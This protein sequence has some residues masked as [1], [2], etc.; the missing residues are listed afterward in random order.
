M[1]VYDG[2]VL[3]KGILH[4]PIAGDVLSEKIKRKLKADLDYV[5][6][7]HYRIAKKKPVD[8]DEKPDIQLRELNG[9]TESF[10]DNQINVCKT[11]LKIFNDPLTHMIENY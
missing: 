8:P 3:K 4:Q 10:N 2:F 7:P 5:V 11:A 9:L 6:T 1:P